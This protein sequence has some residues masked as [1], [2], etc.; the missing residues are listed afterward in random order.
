MSSVT[1]MIAVEP[2]KAMNLK[3]CE[4]YCNNSAAITVL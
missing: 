3:L 4:M 1:V 2:T